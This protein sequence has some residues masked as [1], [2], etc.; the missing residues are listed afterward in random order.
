MLREFKFSI[1]TPAERYYPEAAGERVLLQGVT[2]CCL[3]RD[4]G[5]SVVDFK[6]DRVSPGGEAA[7]GERYRPQLEAY[8]EALSRIFGCPVR[9]KLLY[10]FSTDAL[11]CL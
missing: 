2:D 5:V 3:F 10:F 7:A 4:G 6:T 11:I 8:A 1:L 9:E